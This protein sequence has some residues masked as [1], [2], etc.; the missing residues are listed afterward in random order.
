MGSAYKSVQDALAKAGPSDAVRKQSD[1]LKGLCKQLSEECAV[2]AENHRNALE[3]DRDKEDN[4]KLAF[5]AQLQASLARFASETA[6]LD[7]QVAQALK[8]WEV[9]PEE[10][11]ESTDKPAAW[12]LNAKGSGG[13]VAAARVMPVGS[14]WEG[15]ARGLV[16]K[17]RFEH[18]ITARVT[19]VEGDRVT[20][21]VTNPNQTRDLIM[22]VGGDGAVKVI[23]SPVSTVKALTPKAPVG[24]WT[25]IRLMGTV[26]GQ[27]LSFTGSFVAN[28]AKPIAITYTLRRE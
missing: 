18:K 16:G 28:K 8:G 7:E 26:G 17:D 3:R 23:D 13:N 10:G 19:A 4:S 6:E 24:E 9:A 25:E 15:H 11:V 1:A 12:P 20:L 14:A 5:R 22:T 2:V 21:R 27:R